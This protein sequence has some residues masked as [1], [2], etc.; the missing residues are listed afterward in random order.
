MPMNRHMCAFIVGASERTVRNAIS[1]LRNEG[2]RVCSDSHGRGYWLAEDEDD[3][4]AFRSEYISR[5]TEITKTVKAMDEAGE[6]QITLLGS[7]RAL[8]NG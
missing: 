2:V 1:I 6:Q 8:F 7:L 5:A 3:Y 4:L